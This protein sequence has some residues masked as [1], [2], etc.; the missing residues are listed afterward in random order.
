MTIRVGDILKLSYECSEDIYYL[1]I[2]FVWNKQY[3]YMDLRII[4]LC[5]DYK[6]MKNIHRTPLHYFESSIRVPNSCWNVI[7]DAY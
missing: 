5:D 4:E 3:S 1:V 7:T 2:D 6:Y